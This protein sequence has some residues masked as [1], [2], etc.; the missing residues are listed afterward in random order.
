MRSPESDSFRRSSPRL[1]KWSP[2]RCA[3]SSSGRAKPARPETPVRRRLPCRRRARAPVA[4]PPAESERTPP[5]VRMFSEA[6]RSSRLCVAAFRRSSKAAATRTTKTTNDRKPPTTTNKVLLR[7]Y[8]SIAAASNPWAEAHDC[9]RGT[10]RANVSALVATSPT[11]TAIAA[12]PSRA[13]AAARPAAIKPVCATSTMNHAV[14]N[15]PWASKC[16]GSA[17]PRV[18]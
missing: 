13:C 7:K 2:A 3:G 4:G 11:A 15:N 12:T 10:K 8:C 1:P 9:T 16:G 5:T 14:T 6:T 17:R 18:A